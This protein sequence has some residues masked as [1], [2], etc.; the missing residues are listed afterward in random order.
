[1]TTTDPVPAPRAADPPA[2]TE[3][4]LAAAAALG[5]TPEALS[6]AVAEAWLA[7]LDETLA[8]AAPATTE[9]AA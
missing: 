4:Q 6:W 8:G 1:M 3:R 5:T 7:A 9:Q 2:Y